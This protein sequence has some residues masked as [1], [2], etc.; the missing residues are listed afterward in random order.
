MIKSKPVVLKFGGSSVRS[1]SGFENT[2]KIITQLREHN[3]LIVVVSAFRGVT[4]LLIRFTKNEFD[5]S[6]AETLLRKEYF[7]VGR[8]VLH[9]EW[10]FQFTADFEKLIY[11][12]AEFGRTLDWSDEDKAEV[13][14]IGELASVLLLDHALKERRVSCI[15]V[16]PRLL[17]RAVKSG[18]VSDVD[19]DET[20]RLCQ[21]WYADVQERTVRISAGYF[22]SNPEGR[23]SLLGRGGS[24]LSAS[25]IARS[26]DSPAL[27]RWTDVDGVY[28]S[29][30]RNDDDA[31][32]IPSLTFKDALK[33]TQE[34][35]SGLQRR[36]LDPLIGQNIPVHIGSTFEPELAGTWVDGDHESE[37]KK[38]RSRYPFL[39]VSA[40]I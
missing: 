15:R 37:A 12:L 29:D 14:A 24:D 3:E 2:I 5:A 28:T 26:L 30:P 40:G 20:R 36:S 32:V 22:A 39:Q 35:H 19:Y 11:P 17:I 7:H 9:P 23:T 8:S 21:S 27:L 38:P 33:K 10:F 4:D 18:L 25:V 31:R 13:I 16:D 1:I 34:G 6:E